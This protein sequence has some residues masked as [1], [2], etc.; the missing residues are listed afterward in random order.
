MKKLSYMGWVQ[1]YMLLFVCLYVLPKLDLTLRKGPSLC[2]FFKV[3]TYTI[4]FF[5]RIR[6]QYILQ[7][8]LFH[9]ILTL[10][11]CFL[12]LLQLTC[13]RQIWPWEKPWLI[14]MPVLLLDY[15]LKTGQL[16]HSAN[17]QLRS[18]RVKSCKKTPPFQCLDLSKLEL[19]MQE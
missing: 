18:K 9:Q 6:I 14:W 3:T 19:W 11:F 1:S 13:T 5:G 17:P 7:Y 8:L 10:F 16:I 12:F 2:S 15:W 4:N